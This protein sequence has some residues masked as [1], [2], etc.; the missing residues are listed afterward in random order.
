MEDKKIV[1][2]L[3]ARTESA[4]GA[5]EKR[6][7]RLLHQI[8]MNILERPQ[9]A[10]ECVND[11]YF[12]I[13]NA[14]PPENPDPLRPYVCRVGRNIALNRLRENRAKK[15]SSC[16][17]L[18][19]EELADILPDRRTEELLSARALGRAIDRFL[20]TQSRESRILFLR[21]YWFGDSLRAAAK[22]VGLSPNAASVRLHRLRV[23]LKE[24]L[25]GEELYYE[26]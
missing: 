7:G 13:W 24:Y 9:D 8:A 20:A 21:R 23:E 1:A 14:I 10:Q 19:L 15:R 5:L 11:S 25:I 16:Y 18:S 12:A 17:D 4:L 6:F 26:G 3:W 22:L 2:L